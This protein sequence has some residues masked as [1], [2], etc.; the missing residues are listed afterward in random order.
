MLLQ[1]AVV[2]VV[3]LF[4]G[5]TLAGIGYIQD[6]R[7]LIQRQEYEQYLRNKQTT[8]YMQKNGIDF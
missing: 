2:I 8:W 6:R 7:Q 4:T 1:I 3:A 5:L